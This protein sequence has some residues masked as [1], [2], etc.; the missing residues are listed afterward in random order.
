MKTYNKLVRDRIPEII[1]NAGLE[2]EYRVAEDDEMIKLLTNKLQEEVEEF[3]ENPSAEEIADI[4][5]VLSALGRVHK[6][7]LSEIKNKKLMKNVNRGSFKD[8]I[9]LISAD[10]KEIDTIEKYRND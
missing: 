2:C 5:E 3:I 4:L 9:F 10:E 8:K 6:I 1:E 7:S